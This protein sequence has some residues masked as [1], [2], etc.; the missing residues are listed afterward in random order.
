MVGFCGIMLEKQTLEFVKIAEDEVVLIVYPGHDYCEKPFDTLGNQKRKNKTL[1]ARN[2]EEF[3]K[4][5]LEYLNQFAFICPMGGAGDRL[6]LFNKKT[7]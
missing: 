6:N 3:T 2:I 5:G 1:L 4:I 7:K